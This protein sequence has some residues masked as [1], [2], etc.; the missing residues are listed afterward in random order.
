MM[1][2]ETRRHWLG[3][4]VRLML[5]SL[6]LVLL[7]LGIGV[8]AAQDAI[9]T[10][11]F[12]R[13]AG[14]EAGSEGIYTIR[15]DGTGERP[16]LLFG[17]VGYPYDLENG[18]YR[19]PAWSPDGAQIAF[20]A[21]VANRSLLV[22]VDADGTN[23]RTVHEVESDATLTRRI[24]FPRWV[25]N[26][27]R[28]SFGFTEFDPNTGVLSANGVQS[29]RLDGSGLQ[30]IR[31]DVSLTYDSGAPVQSDSMQPNFIV[32]SHAW[33]PDGQQLAI[34]AFN[35][36][37]Y[38][39]DPTGARLT[40]LESS[41]WAAGG[42]D[43]SPDGSRITSSHWY[44]ASYTA[45]DTDLQALVPMPTDMLN[46]TIESVAW[47][48]DGRQIAYTSYVINT[49]GETSWHVR[50]AVVDVATGEEREIVRTPDF[51]RGEMPW[52]IACVDWQPE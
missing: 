37:V 12:A 34:S 23:A 4:V 13:L 40:P 20:N 8:T 14:G 19:C 45:Q 31:G 1:H 22:V 36:R 25:P 15:A 28:L 32:L 51:R 48:P 11:T 49:G 29:V 3:A 24:H 17:E 5:L 21:A 50:L 18:G 41:E 26:S 35:R 9:G 27:D 39:S 42:V 16:L 2:E 7:A 44:V 46:E 33:S 10:L 52:S 38:L 6:I 43:W 47:S 30:T